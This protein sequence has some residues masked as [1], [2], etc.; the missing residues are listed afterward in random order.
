MSSLSC[1]NKQLSGN[2]H[3][4]I[5]LLTKMKFRRTD[6]ISE[7]TKGAKNG[8]NRLDEDYPVGT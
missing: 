8:W 1:A 7:V 5:P 2:R 3:T 6:N 4:K